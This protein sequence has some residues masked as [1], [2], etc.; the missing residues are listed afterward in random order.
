MEQLLL[1]YTRLRRDI[2]IAVDFLNTR[3]K[4]P[5][6]YDWLKL[7]RCL[8]YLKGKIGSKL[9]FTTDELSVVKWWVDAS[10]EIHDECKGHTGAG[11][12]LGKG[13]V[14][15]FSRKQ[16]IQGKSSTEDYI[17]GADYEAPQKLWTK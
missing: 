9:N 16:K 2:Q 15:S 14:I 3:E 13:A 4:N 17:I 11:T 8:K 5:E 12:T 6:K 7:R 1:L 10:Y